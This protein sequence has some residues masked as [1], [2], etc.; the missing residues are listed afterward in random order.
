[1]KSYENSLRK[2]KFMFSDNSILVK[3]PKL[4]IKISGLNKDKSL[5]LNVMS[6]NRIYKRKELENES[7]F[8]KEKVV[9]L[10]NKLIEA[11]LL[12]RHDLGTEAKYS[13]I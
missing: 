8:N 1:M 12:I 13:K 11:G 5:L 7:G 3:L 9:R 4:S 6:N 10:V 2:P